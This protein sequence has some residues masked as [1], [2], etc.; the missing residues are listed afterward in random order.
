MDGNAD[1]TVF[2]VAVGTAAVVGAVVGSVVVARVRVARVERV[3]SDAEVVDARR[4][5]SDGCGVKGLRALC[6][7][8]AS[9]SGGT[10]MASC[11]APNE[12]IG[13]CAVAQLIES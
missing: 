1:A 13:G 2:V 12:H 10:R 4:R 9:S 3:A 5:G 6:M 7:V 8:A 11:A